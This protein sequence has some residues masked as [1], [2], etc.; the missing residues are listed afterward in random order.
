[1]NLGVKIF[2]SLFLSVFLAVGLFAGYM[3][4]H[5][6]FDTF[7]IRSWTPTPATILESKVIPGSGGDHEF[8]VS[9]SFEVGG[10]SYTGHGF[11]DP[12]EA[13]FYS[14]DLGY[15]QGLEYEYAAG[16]EITAYVNPKDPQQAVLE[17]P[18]FG[19]ALFLFIPL[20]FIL[21]SLGGLY[22]VWSSET[23]RTG[24]KHVRSIT[25]RSGNNSKGGGKWV[26]LFMGVIFTLVGGVLFY[27]L[28]ILPMLRIEEAKSWEPVDATVLSSEVLTHY[29]DDGNTYS[30]EIAYEYQVEGR[31]LRGNRYQ[32][33]GGSSSGYQGKR[34]VVEQY[35]VGKEITIYVNPAEATE[36]VI[37]REF[38]S[39]MWFGL[40]PL[41]FFGSGLLMLFGS[42]FVSG[43][44]DQEW[45]PEAVEPA[46]L[47]APS[48]LPH[49]SP[50]GSGG[51]L[52]RSASPMGKLIGTLF[53]AVFWNGLVSVFLFIAIKSHREG[54][55]EWFL[56]VFLIPF[57]LVGLGA[58]GGVFYFILALFNPHPV[59]HASTT[60]PALGEGMT[61]N[62]S[63][64]G[65]GERIS[66]LTFSL[67]AEESATYRRGTNTVTD[68]H[69]L[70]EQTLLE[71]S[72]PMEIM[73]GGRFE[74]TIPPH[75]MHTF[76]ADNN[77][78]TWKLKLHGDIKRWPDVND[79]FPLVVR[80]M[81]LEAMD[82]DG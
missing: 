22:G 36:S 51:E 26:L 28:F 44:K 30:I 71:T 60:S 52:Q 50:P 46:H 45:L 61:I 78:I 14:D 80:P 17:H 73:R 67:V 29:G 2:M 76:E 18:S 21:V 64:K 56:T 37:N 6:V 8:T 34:A 49:H 23:T 1:M 16:F 20:V 65:R 10:Q 19:I 66:K 48:A 24:K 79:E 58:I 82:R 53:F 41:V 77:R 11:D 69:T 72:H 33:M 38:T 7:A 42:F 68:T 39:E 81:A 12:D 25:R 27:V 40:I 5:E 4:V 13:S 15:L 9:Y 57:V 63:F 31:L 43:T 35:P 62:W 54:N 47:G 3:L 55:P 70:F 59:V 32:F 75:A 74:A